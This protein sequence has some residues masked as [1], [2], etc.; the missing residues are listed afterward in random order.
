MSRRQAHSPA[1][2][3]AKG[4]S[5]IGLLSMRTSWSPVQM[6]GA[7]TRSAAV[8]LRILL[9]LHTASTGPAPTARRQERSA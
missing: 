6:K 5:S 3:R 1:T 7:L 9:T 8:P 2:T 4:Q